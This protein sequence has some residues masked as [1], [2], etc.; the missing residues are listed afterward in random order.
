MLNAPLLNLACGRN[1]WPSSPLLSVV[2]LSFLCYSLDDSIDGA[3]R[4]LVYTNSFW[5][6]PIETK[7]E[8]AGNEFF[9]VRLSGPSKKGES[10]LCFR[11]C[12]DAWLLLCLS[13][14]SSWSSSSNARAVYLVR[15]GWP[16]RKSNLPLVRVPRPALTFSGSTYTDAL[17]P[18]RCVAF[19][20]PILDYTCAIR[21]TWGS[22]SVKRRRHRVDR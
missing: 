4:C 7:D 11:F 17:D 8:P 12:A 5:G 20:Q 13:L 16:Y 19:D 21:H 18:F 14:S 3:V 6:L 1:H 22:L 10:G 15:C 9:A 2:P